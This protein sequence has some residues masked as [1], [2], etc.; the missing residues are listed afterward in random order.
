MKKMSLNKLNS[1]FQSIYLLIIVSLASCGGSNKTAEDYFQS[2][3]Y[4]KAYELFKPRAKAGEADAQAYLGLMHYLGLVG[5]RDLQKAGIWFEKAAKQKHPGAQLNYALVIEELAKES[6]DHIE[7]YKWYYVAYE[8][9]NQEA[10]KHLK[11]LVEKQRIFHNQ[12]VYAQKEME[13]YIDYE[14]L[15]SASKTD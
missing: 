7:A 8:N 11:M 3:N 9:G 14:R 1:L 15:Q 6:K 5:K 2:H 12:Q 13:Q 4:E 10:E